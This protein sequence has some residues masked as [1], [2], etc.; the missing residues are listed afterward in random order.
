MPSIINPAR[1][2]W[3][4]DLLQHCQ[5]A[6][7]KIVIQLAIETGMGRSELLSIQWKHVNMPRRLAY[8]SVAI[9]H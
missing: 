4:L 9:P 1:R 6:E 8:P 3:G 7:L 2:K 5:S